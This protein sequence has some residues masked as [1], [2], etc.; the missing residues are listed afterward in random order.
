M[1]ALF[2]AVFLQQPFNIMNKS[3]LRLDIVRDSETTR[4]IKERGPVKEQ[5]G[6]MTLMLK[7]KRRR[8]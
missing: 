4:A 2:D 7:K 1:L 6:K 5:L 8:K 3:H